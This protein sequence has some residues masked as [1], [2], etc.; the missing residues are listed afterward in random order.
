MTRL[1][2]D[3][4]AAVPPTAQMA[5]RQGRAEIL[6]N[7][8]LHADE[9]RRRAQR[10]TKPILSLDLLN[11]LLAMPLSSA[12][13]AENFSDYDWRRLKAGSR[14]GAV[15][16][17]DR[18]ARPHAT[19][20][21]VPPLTVRH[22][23]VRARHWRTGLSTASQFAPYCSRDLILDGLP[24]DDL[25]L[26]LEA[27]YLGVGVCVRSDDPHEPVRR[28]IEPARFRPARYTGASWLFTERLLVEN[29]VMLEC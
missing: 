27:N 13:P 11:L 9:L 28:V 22:A 21:A 18:E 29:A 25:E 1:V 5:L 7:V 24:S 16:I 2:V 26:R 17:N 14:V 6:L 8:D 20:L 15:D 3:D 10:D 23:T 19:R 12:V 4:T